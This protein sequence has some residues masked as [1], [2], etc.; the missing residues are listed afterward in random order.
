MSK[1]FLVSKPSL[2]FVRDSSIPMPPG[3][4]GW[5]KSQLKAVLRCLSISGQ[6]AQSVT[7]IFQRL[8]KSK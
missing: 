4:W 7:P 6:Q 5:G 2:P 1:S 3:L 8:L